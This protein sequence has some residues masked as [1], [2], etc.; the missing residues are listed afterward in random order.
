MSEP[1]PPEEPAETGETGGG[2]GEHGAAAP[3]EGVP[4]A[5]AE[6]G[7]AVLEPRIEDGVWVYELTATPV[8]WEILPDI[9]VTA[10]TYNG[11]VPG[12]ELRIPYGQRVRVHVTNDLPDPTTVHWHGIAVPNEMDGV[13]GVTRR[14]APSST[15]RTTRRTARSGS[16]WQARS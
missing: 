3:T 8:R 16:A 7:G 13:P 11:T 15:T 9:H 14:A 5:T 6:R 4:E 1:M 10:W 12:P 2:H